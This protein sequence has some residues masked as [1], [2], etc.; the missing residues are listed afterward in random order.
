MVVII[1]GQVVN[2][3]KSTE[4]FS[5]HKCHFDLSYA[6][7]K[8]IL[9]HLISSVTLLGILPNSPSLL[10]SVTVVVGRTSLT[11]S[12]TEWMF[13]R[14]PTGTRLINLRNGQIKIYVT[15]SLWV[16]FIFFPCH[17]PEESSL[18]IGPP[19][20]DPHVAGLVH[21]DVVLGAGGQPVTE[22]HPVLHNVSI[23]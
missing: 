21:Q 11:L 7:K 12:P 2:T 14:L 18:D 1:S 16:T 13:R 10:A 20:V 8:V 9:S 4:I 15:L 23:T 19:H 17:E 6:H 5:Q 22:P 3:S